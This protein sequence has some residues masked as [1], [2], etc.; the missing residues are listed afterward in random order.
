MGLLQ[1][2]AIVV[3]LAAVLAFVNYRLVGLPTTIGVMLLSLMVSAALVAADYFGVL[4]VREQTGSWWLAID[5]NR[6]LMDG[7]LSFLL[8]AGA[9]QVN[10]GDLWKHRFSIGVLASVGVV[11]STAIIG[12][13]TYL[14][15]PYLGFELSFVYCLLFGALI[16]P[17]DPIAVLALLKQAG[18]S[19]ELEIVQRRPSRRF[20]TSC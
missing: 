16:T 5:F 19:Q 1:I 20:R 12:C 11:L 15:V 10:L 4:A 8:F 6:T 3:S 13:V 7:M 17:T 2:S 14:L 18:V 9:L